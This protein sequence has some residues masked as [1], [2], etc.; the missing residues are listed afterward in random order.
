[1]RDERLGIRV[2]DRLRCTNFGI[3]KTFTFSVKDP[4][5]V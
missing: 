1:M 4:H 5:L 3:Y 2:M